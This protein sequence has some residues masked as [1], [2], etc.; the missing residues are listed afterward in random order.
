[1]TGSLL[2]ADEAVLLAASVCDLLLS[3]V[4]AASHSAARRISTFEWLSAGKR[5]RAFS[6]WG[7]RF[8]PNGGFQVARGLFK[9]EGKMGREVDRRIGAAPAVMQTLRGSVV[10]KRE[11]R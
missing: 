10:V 5:W 1:M 4:G 8:C 6:R 7:R 11:L 9:S 2:F 3:L